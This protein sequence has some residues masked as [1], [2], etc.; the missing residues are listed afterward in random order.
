[1]QQGELF[2]IRRAIPRMQIWSNTVKEQG[3]EIIILLLFCFARESQ[4][5]DKGR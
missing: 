4:T 2:I 1:M 5:Q 3:L